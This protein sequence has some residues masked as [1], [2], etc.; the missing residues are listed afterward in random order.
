[1]RDRERERNEKWRER[2]RNERQR[3]MRERGR[4]MRERQRERDLS[5]VNAKEF[6]G[7]DSLSQFI[8][9][10]TITFNPD[11]ASFKQGGGAKINE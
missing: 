5:R 11:C 1:M 10:R 3:E 6:V 2:E 8:T 9:K 4:E 7:S